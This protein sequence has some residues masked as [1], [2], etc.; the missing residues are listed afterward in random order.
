MAN[1]NNVADVLKL[2][3]STRNFAAKIKIVNDGKPKPTLDSLVN[4][5]R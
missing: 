3:F 1:E 5:Q 2:P 4:K